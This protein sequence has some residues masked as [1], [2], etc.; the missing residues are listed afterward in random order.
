ML[1]FDIENWTE[2]F[3]SIKKNKLRTFLTGFSISWGIFMFCILLSSGNGLRNG[4]ASN[5]GSRSVNSVQYW[6]RSTSIPHEGL[7]SKRSIKL[8]EKDLHL[9]KT[10]VPEAD[11]I[12]PMI[13]R[14]LSISY[15]NYNTSNSSIEGV[16]PNYLNINGIKI[17]ENSGRFINDFDLK[18][19]RKVM[20]INER[21]CKIL[22]REEDPIGKLILAGG[23]SYT[24]IGVFE[25]DSWGNDEKAYVP[26]TTAQ[27]LYNNGSGI[28]DIS[29]TVNGLNTKAENEAFEEDFRGKLS[30][31]HLFN[32][33][34]K[35]AI[36]IWNQLSRFLE[37][38]GMFNAI[39]AFIWIIGI[40]TLLAGMIGVSNIMLIT[41]RERTREIGIRK[42]LGARPSAILGS[43]LLESVFI[44]S[45]FG[46]IG[47]FLGVGLGELVNTALSSPGMEGLAQAFK[48]PTIDVN[49]A[50]GAML[51]LIFS[52]LIAG[53]FPALRAVKISPVEAMRAE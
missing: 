12:S 21:L 52:G 27:L 37:F 13:L 15:Q 32:S 2:I 51:V 5:F 4:L 31:L 8:D 47:M 26:F 7:P 18:E 23:L 40:G 20:V 39:S 16:Y 19:K 30:I 41:V 50:V 46:Y 24:V 36:G 10:Q 3:S 25:E 48:N 42:A 9:L 22:F 35:R 43:I 28:H 49:I 6:G 38:N 11:N 44:T 53:Y 45:I 29:F 33:K 17:K 14:N 34:D 1:L